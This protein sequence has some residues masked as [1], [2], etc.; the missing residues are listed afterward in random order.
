[1]RPMEMIQNG[2]LGQASYFLALGFF[3]VN[4]R[5]LL[6]TLRMYDYHK[7]L[8][9]KLYIYQELWELFEI[10]ISKNLEIISMMHISG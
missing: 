5:N 2:K 8:T 9:L 6:D 10:P 3:M 7:N 1:M 4:Y